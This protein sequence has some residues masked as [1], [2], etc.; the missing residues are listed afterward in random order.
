MDVSIYMCMYMCKILKTKDKI[1]KSAN[2]L[3][4]W[5]FVVAFYIIVY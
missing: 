5:F 3:F 1:L 2:S 4:L